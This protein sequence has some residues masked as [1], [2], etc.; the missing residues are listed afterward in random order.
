MS[1]N[2]KYNHQMEIND[3]I[4]DAIVNAI[5]R[6]ELVE[7]LSDD[8]AA[9]VTGGLTAETTKVALSIK[10]DVI[11]AGFKPIQPIKPICPPLIVGLIALPNDAKLTS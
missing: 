4:D 6:R 1:E 10:P 3:L 8:E 11:I 5:T 2:K 9:G 7:T